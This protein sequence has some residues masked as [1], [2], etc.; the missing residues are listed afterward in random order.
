MVTSGESQHPESQ[1]QRDAATTRASILR[2]A[3]AEFANLGPAGA[4]IDAIAAAASV[5]KRMLYHYFGSKDGLYRA[6]VAQATASLA[7]SHLAS[8]PVLNTQQLRLLAWAG[9]DQANWGQSPSSNPTDSNAASLVPNQDLPFSDDAVSAYLE[10]VLQLVA[11]IGGPLLEP[12]LAANGEGEA[13][14]FRAAQQQ[15]HELLTRR[16]ARQPNPESGAKQKVTLR[17]TSRLRRS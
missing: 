8:P 12:L 1:H 7:N 17:A 15:V 5:N 4:R 16:L 13:V 9:L 6:V 2:A 14:D 11:E 3:G 10:T